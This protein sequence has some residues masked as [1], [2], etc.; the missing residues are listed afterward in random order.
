MEKA[1]ESLVSILQDS[2]VPDEEIKLVVSKDGLHLA[3]I[4]LEKNKMDIVSAM[5]ATIYGAGETA[6]YATEKGN[7]EFLTLHSN[8]TCLYIID[9]GENALLAVV[10]PRKTSRREILTAMMRIAEQVKELIFS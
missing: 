2:N 6:F 5:C 10:A 8:D 3:S 7:L 9:A 1:I 4:G